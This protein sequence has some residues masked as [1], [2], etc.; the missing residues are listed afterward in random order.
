MFQDTINSIKAVLYERISS[1]L[2]GAFLSSWLIWNWKTVLYVFSSTKV[3]E[4][5]YYIDKKLYADSYEFWGTIV[6]FPLISAFLFILIYPFLS[7]WTYSFWEKAQIKLKKLKLEI[8]GETPLPEKEA[9]KLRLAHLALEKAFYN[10]LKT[11]NDEVQNLKEQILNLNELLSEDKNEE[12]KQ[13]L[14]FDEEQDEEQLTD[15]EQSALLLFKEKDEL[16]M[17]DFIN[18][19]PYESVKIQYSVECLLD[20]VYLLKDWN[21]KVSSYTYKLTTKGKGKVVKLLDTS[22]SV[23]NPN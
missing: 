11:K 19:L 7:Y 6:I 17:V 16:F 1:P 4:K 14:L 13:V 15:A 22:S 8:E 18:Q 23:D 3:S 10:Q 9:Q 2:A 5:I 20:R 12:P 21:R